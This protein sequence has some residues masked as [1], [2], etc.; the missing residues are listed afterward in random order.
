MATDQILSAII[1][2]LRSAGNE[3]VRARQARDN[4]GEEVFGVTSGDLRTIAKD[5]K[6]QHDLGLALWRV[7]NQ[8]AK[9][10]ATLILKPKLLSAE[11]VD[12]MVGSVKSNHVADWLNSNI[13]KNHPAKESLRLRWMTSTH[14]MRGRAGWSLT[15]ERVNKNPE[16]LDLEALLSRI[17]AELVDAPP[18]TQWTM[19]YCLASIGIEFPEHRPRALTIGERLGVYRDYP[20]SKGCTS[21]FAPIWITSVASKR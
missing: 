18:A 15:T 12:S 20:T 7:E 11:D 2:R 16:G 10:L 4:P 14:P 13:V 9:L 5:Y 21:P 17:E 6:N 19:N 3:T 8:D 1:E